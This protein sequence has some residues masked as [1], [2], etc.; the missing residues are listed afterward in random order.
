MMSSPEI[1][2]TVERLEFLSGGSAS[3]AEFHQ[4][5]AAISPSFSKDLKLSKGD[6]LVI[7]NLRGSE[8][9]LSPRT[10]ERVAGRAVWISESKR[11]KLAVGQKSSIRVQRTQIAGGTSIRISCI[12]KS[13]NV[14]GILLFK[15]D[16]NNLWC[17]SAPHLHYLLFL[18]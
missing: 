8:T 1:K 2:G 17:G 7:K 9:V 15:P 3:A 6:M 4:T 16:F 14:K 12:S 5:E 13:K 18:F 11:N 10:N